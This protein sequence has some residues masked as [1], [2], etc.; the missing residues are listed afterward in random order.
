VPIFFA[1]IIFGALF[2]DSTQPDVDFGSNIAGAI[3][4]GFA[5]SLS[6]LFG[7]NYLLALALVFYL[8]SGALRRPIIVPIPISAGS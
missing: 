1:G 2:R 8:L 5:E 6:L 4:G 7:F 3:L